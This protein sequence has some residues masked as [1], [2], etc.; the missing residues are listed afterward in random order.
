MI[1]LVRR[2]VVLMGSN[3]GKIFTRMG[4]ATMTTGVRPIRARGPGD[5]DGG[6]HR[7]HTSRRRT[8][9]HRTQRQFGAVRVRRVLY[10]KL[11][12][13]PELNVVRSVRERYEC[14]CDRTRNVA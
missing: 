7:L 5:A 1:F 13:T 9:S 6:Y 11:I 4:I 8:V 10:D 3:C 2:I 12:I 14:E